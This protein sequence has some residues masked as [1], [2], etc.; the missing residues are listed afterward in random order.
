M[1]MSQH[2]GRQEVDRLG[3]WCREN[4]PTLNNNKTKEMIVNFWRNSPATTPPP[5]HINGTAVEVVPSIKYLGVHLSNTL[6]WHENSMSFVKKA[7]HFL[8]LYFL[9]KFT[10]AGLNSNILSS[11]YRYVVESVLTSCIT[12]WYCSCTEAEKNALQRVVKSIQKT[13]GC[14]YPP[15]STIFISQCTDRATCIM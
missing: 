2:T 6:T 15:L 13:T 10:G 8:H 5:P 7:H 14:S 12:V 1:E 4:N 9:R 3:L 11:F